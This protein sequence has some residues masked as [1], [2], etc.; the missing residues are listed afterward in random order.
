MPT[1]THDA[2]AL[3]LPHLGLGL[4][5]LHCKEPT[6]ATPP[7]PLRLPIHRALF[8]S[9]IVLH[10][11]YIARLASPDLRGSRARIVRCDGIR[12]EDTRGY[13]TQLAVR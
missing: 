12:R 13:A 1:H 2:S 7:I 9:R 3:L 10:Q 5:I 8:P 6:S 4:N 11:S